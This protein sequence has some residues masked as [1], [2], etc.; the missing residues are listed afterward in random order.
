MARTAGR[1]G[2]D[3]RRRRGVSW[4]VRRVASDLEVSPDQLRRAFLQ[5]VVTTPFFFVAIVALMTLISIFETALR[6]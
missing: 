5:A 6:V 3:L 2:H 1:Q 4:L